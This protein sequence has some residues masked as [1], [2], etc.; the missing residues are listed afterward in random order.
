MT[1]FEG[2]PRCQSKNK[3]KNEKINQLIK[4]KLQVRKILITSIIII[5]K[6]TKTNLQVRHKFMIRTIILHKLIKS[7]KTKL[8]T[9]EPIKMN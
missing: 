1:L 4:M 3:N 9:N 6:L 5:H 7:N 2:G 8:I